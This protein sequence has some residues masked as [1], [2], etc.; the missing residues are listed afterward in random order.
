MRGCR[1]K[2]AS[3]MSEEGKEDSRQYDAGGKYIHCCIDT[4]DLGQVC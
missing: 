2:E 1:E 4:V 3:E